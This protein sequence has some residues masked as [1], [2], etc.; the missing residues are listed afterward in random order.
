MRIGTGQHLDVAVPWYRSLDV[1]RDA[2]APSMPWSLSVKQS[3]R[4]SGRC[5]VQMSAMSLSP[6]RLSISV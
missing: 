3:T 1:P 2:A 4:M 6:V 5:T